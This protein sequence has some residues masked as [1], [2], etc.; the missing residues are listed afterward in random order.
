MPTDKSKYALIFI[1]LHSITKNHM[2]DIM[3]IV[4]DLPSYRSGSFLLYTPAHAHTK[5]KK[6]LMTLM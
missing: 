6:K 2:T 1:T 4:A 5:D 3:T